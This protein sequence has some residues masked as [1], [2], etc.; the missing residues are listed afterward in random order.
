V[1]NGQE[2]NVDVTLLERPSQ[3]QR[4][5]LVRDRLDRD[6]TFVDILGNEVLY[7]DAFL[8]VLGSQSALGIEVDTMT[9]DLREFFGADRDE[10]ILIV[11]IGDDSLG[12]AAGLRVGDVII[13]IDGNSVDSA[14]NLRSLSRAVLATGNSLTVTV[15]R[16]QSEVEVVVEPEED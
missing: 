16:D 14:G 10:G 7:T 2:Q 15:M 3:A 5:S 8:S 1:R 11:L 4:L 12:G 9:P 6:S 13:A